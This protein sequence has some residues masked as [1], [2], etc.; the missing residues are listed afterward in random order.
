MT[1]LLISCRW[2]FLSRRR[3]IAT[4]AAGFTAFVN[5]YALQ[6][7]LPLLA[8]VFNTD[9]QGVSLSV[10]ATTLAVAVASPF[11]GWLVSRFTRRTL[12][13]VAVVGLV[14]SGFNVA[15]A[16]TLQ[17][18]I[19]W[20]FVQGLFLPLLIAGVMAF[21]A[22]DF[23][24]C[25]VG[26]VMANYVAWTIVGGF[27]GRWVCGLV[28][29]EVGWR[30]G[31]Y[32]LACLNAVSGFVLW[33]AIP[34]R[35][36]RLAPEP[37]HGLRETFETLTDPTLRTAYLTGFGSLMTLTGVFTYITFYLAGPRFA[38]GPDSL[39][40]MFCVYLLG[41]V[42]TPL[43]GRS[44]ARVGH[45]RTVRMASR[46]SI[47]GLLLTLVPHLGCV[48]AGLSLISVAAFA[49]QSTASSY[50]AQTGGQQRT[51][52][53]GIYL[54]FY[55]LGGCVGSMLP[56]FAWEGAGWFGCAAMFAVVQSAIFRLGK[57][58]RKV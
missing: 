8:E 6:S 11:A 9:H 58:Y 35:R 38:L 43:I 49:S 42:V 52:A 5:L 20:R 46:V 25:R 48:V 51:L 36:V 56:G 44:L 27:A 55:Y 21:I 53:S 4:G 39:G 3:A 13:S 40:R 22:E 12:T 16:A 47:C 1:S 10:G 2:A 32:F 14:V 24:R 23:P 50:V 28:A 34:V 29:A 15:A 30:S 37:P 33:L 45:R 41:V 54:S 57:G 26:R 19:A 18:L 7:I 31:L 17:T